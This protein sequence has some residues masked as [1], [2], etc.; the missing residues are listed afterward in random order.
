MRRQSAQAEKYS[1]G[2]FG[3]RIF[4]AAVLAL[5]V[6]ACSGSAGEEPVLSDAGLPDAVVPLTVVGADDSTES[7]LI[8]VDFDAYV[9]SVA[10]VGQLP[11]VV[12]TLESPEGVVTFEG[13]SRTVAIAM[14]RCST[15]DVVLTVSIPLTTGAERAS[16]AT[17]DSLF[18][19]EGCETLSVSVG[20][21]EEL[22]VR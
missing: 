9:R 2:V 20:P 1:R 8:L 22:S 11:L 15:R 7:R 4:A 21:N 3:T 5:V 6:G 17:L 12:V 18:D 16:S 13:R 10:S 19:G 14:P